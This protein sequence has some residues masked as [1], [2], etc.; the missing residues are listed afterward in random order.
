MTFGTAWRPPNLGLI[1]SRPREC[2]SKV[3]ACFAFIACIVC[4]ALLAQF[5]CVIL[6]A[7]A[8]ALSMLNNDGNPAVGTGFEQLIETI[9]QLVKFTV[10]NSDVI[11]DFEPL[12][13]LHIPTDLQVFYDLL[14]TLF[15]V[16][17]NLMML[18]LLIGM[19]MTTITTATT[20][21]TTAS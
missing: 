20:K 14:H 6:V 12:N 9:Y 10:N 4:I 7:F 11:P 2:R 18:N 3:A 19:A 1:H 17:V 21:T 13:I 8:C 16:I 15:N 5:Y